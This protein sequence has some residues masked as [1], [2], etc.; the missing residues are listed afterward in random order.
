MPSLFDSLLKIT[1]NVAETG[2]LMAD[3]TL[4]TVQSSLESLVGQKRLDPPPTPLQ[5]PSDVDLAVSEMANRAVRLL[6]FT[7]MEPGA[8]GKLG[9]ELMEALRFSFG[10]VDWKDPRNLILPL[11]LPLSIGTLMTQQSLRGLSTLEI[12]GLKR[13]PRFVSD[14]FEMFTEIQI[15]VSVRY[16][17][18]ID[19]LNA[20]LK[21]HPGDL[22][23]RM[24]LGKILLKVGRYSDAVKEFVKVAQNPEYVNVAMHESSVANY[25]A[26]NFRQAMLDGSAA[27][28]AN[29]DDDRIRSWMWFVNLLWWNAVWRQVGLTRCESIWP[30]QAHPFVVN[31]STTD[32]CTGS[33]YPIAA[34][35]DA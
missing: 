17:A 13:Y 18:L 19:R 25:R 2:L 3:S 12:V 8:I 20:R 6:R 10:Y 4:R 16:P 33:L 29:P 5:G 15:Y 34:A 26:G 1:T 7:P 27:L 9:E 21:Q 22:N 30:S 28:N 31:A 11:Q 14:V 23:A 35:F 24:E 32:L